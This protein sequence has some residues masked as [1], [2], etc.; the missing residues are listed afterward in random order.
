MTRG[1][2][3]AL[4]TGLVVAAADAGRLDDTR[5]EPVTCIIPAPPTTAADESALRGCEAS[6]TTPVATDGPWIS[7]C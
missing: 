5:P 2:I 1:M 6:L 7:A 3:L 4:L